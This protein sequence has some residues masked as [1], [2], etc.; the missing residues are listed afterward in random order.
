MSDPASNGSGPESLAAD[1]RQDAANLPRWFWRRALAYLIDL[2]LVGIVFTALAIAA[3]VL[4]GAKVLPPALFNSR[5]CQNAETVPES[6]MNTLLPISEGQ[7]HVQRLC[8]V[9]MMGMVSFLEVQLIRTMTEGSLT[10]TQFISFVIDDSGKQ[11]AVYPTDSLLYL[12]APLLFAFA[13]SRYGRT[14][15]KGLLNLHVIDERRNKPGLKRALLREYTKGLPFIV[16]ALI[17]L[18]NAYSLIGLDVPEVARTLPPLEQTVQPGFQYW[19]LAYA[20][21]TVLSIWYFLGSFIRW[22]GH[23]YWDRI[24]VTQVVLSTDDRSLEGGAGS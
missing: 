23:S 12:I 18:Y 1:P 22:R 17:Y 11:I 4:T 20:T 24:A 21:L 3:G 14:I 6:Q 13:L 2:L 7:H 8:K 10:K 19:V 16:L 5:I 15:G 9:T